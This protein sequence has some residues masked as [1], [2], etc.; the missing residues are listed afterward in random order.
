MVYNIHKLKKLV[1]CFT[2][3]QNRETKPVQYNTSIEQQF[4]LASN[5]TATRRDEEFMRLQFN[6]LGAR[7]S[8]SVRE[9]VGNVYEPTLAFQI[10]L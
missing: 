7:V 2:G 8:G 4:Q 10:N 5:C 1:Y 9:K 3:S 6:T